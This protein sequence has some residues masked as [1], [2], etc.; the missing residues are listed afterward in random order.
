MI[1]TTTTILIIFIVVVVVIIFI[2]IIVGTC[3]RCMSGMLSL[4]ART[5]MLDCNSTRMLLNGEK[6]RPA[7][8]SG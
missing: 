8:Q 6:V 4:L 3:W 2:I 7:R 1:I 5:D